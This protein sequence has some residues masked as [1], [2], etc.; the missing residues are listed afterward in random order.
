MI[1]IIF[2]GFLVYFI[3]E[4]GHFLGYVVFNFLNK[5]VFYYKFFIT[6]K[7]L[8]FEYL[9]TSKVQIF[10]TSISGIIFNLLAVVIETKLQT[11]ELSF[12]FISLNC[13]MILN[14]FTSNSEDLKQILSLFN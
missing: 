7:G 6:I 10:I 3:H 14:S 8:C 2:Y 9:T 13:A 1:N 4:L 11:L 12:V 5:G